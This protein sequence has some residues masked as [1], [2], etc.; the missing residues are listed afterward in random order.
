MELIRGL[1]NL[2][3]RHHGCVATIGAFDGVH[4]GHQALLGEL[5]ARGRQMGLPSCV[6]CFEPLPREYFA[7]VES[8]ARLMSFREKFVALRELGI[9]RVLRIRFDKSFSN[10]T[11][12]DFIEQIFIKSLGVQFLVAGD[13][14]RF[15]RGREG[16]FDYL[17]QAGKQFGFE[18]T[19]TPTFAIDGERVS[20]S[21]IREALEAADFATA[22]RLLGR[23][24]KIS[25]K[26]IYGRQL[27]RTLGYPTANLQLRRLRAAMSGVYAVQVK[28]TDPVDQGKSWPAVVNVGTRPTVDDSITAI[29]EAHLL[30]YTGNLY[31]KHLDM[32]FRHRLRDEQ[33]FEG[34]EELK[35]AIENDE[36]ACREYFGLNRN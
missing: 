12:E 27:G 26:V 29:L 10:M 28:G 13:D 31:G 5:I 1:H 23:P 4:R 2:R 36:A 17:Q 16:D 14:F 32:V 24:Y 18:V 3:P 6:I 9:D 34:L 21:R 22:E 25:G 7:P 30:D 20:S 11:A 33:K 8:P 35:S 19:D 15:G